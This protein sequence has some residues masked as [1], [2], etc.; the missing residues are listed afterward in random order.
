[1]TQYPLYR[2]L[3][4]PQGRSELVR[5][6]SPPPGFD[7]RPV[8]PVASRYTDYAI[9]AHPTKTMS[10]IIRV[11][12]RKMWGV[13]KIFKTCGV[14]SNS[15]HELTFPQ[16]FYGHDEVIIQWYLV[17]M[18][19]HYL[20]SML[21]QR[22]EHSVRQCNCKY[23]HFIIQQASLSFSWFKVGSAIKT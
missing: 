23:F 3:G 21:S 1:M 18:P 8:H 11:H 9:P 14:I 17:G 12:W 4:G 6:I 7:H 10:R 2:R 19:S 16:R 13:Y 5:K 20:T 22:A 15:K